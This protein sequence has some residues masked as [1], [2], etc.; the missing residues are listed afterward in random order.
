MKKKI[1]TRRKHERP[2]RREAK[3]VHAKRRESEKKKKLASTST[4]WLRVMPSAIDGD[5]RTDAGRGLFPLR[6]GRRQ[7]RDVDLYIPEGN[8]PSR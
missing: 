1:R 2:P 3:A 7:P 5:P 6:N 4:P 8:S